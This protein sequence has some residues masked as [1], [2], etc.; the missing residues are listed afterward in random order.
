MDLAVIPMRALRQSVTDG[1]TGASLAVA[2]DAAQGTRTVAREIC[3][4]VELDAMALPVRAGADEG[5]NDVDLI[6]R[7]GDLDRELVWYEGG[8][9]LPDRRGF[10]LGAGRWRNSWDERGDDA[11]D[12]QRQEPSPAAKTVHALRIIPDARSGGGSRQRAN[13]REKKRARLPRG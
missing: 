2:Q 11:S 3:A 12:R 13:Q 9:D 8:P 6:G 5:P 7:A 10:H 1:L 4:V